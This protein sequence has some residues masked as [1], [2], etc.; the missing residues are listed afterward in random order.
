MKNSKYY[1][2]R[3]YAKE[4]HKDQ[5]RKFD[6]KPYIV[7]PIRVSYLIKKFKGQSKNIEALRIIALLHDTLEDTNTTFLEIKEIFGNLIA[8]VVKELTS[9]KDKIKLIG[10]AEYLKNK[11]KDM[12]DY[13]LVLKLVDRLDNVSD[14]PLAPSEFVQKYKNETQEIISFI[15]QNRK[16]TKTQKRIVDEIKEKIK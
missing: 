12:T 10:K 5:I 2:A 6:G 11:M 9:D 15:E 8:S 3:K 1:D 13:S 4:K 7:H 16:L 14:F